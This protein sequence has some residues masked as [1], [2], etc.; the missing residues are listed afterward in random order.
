MNIKTHSGRAVKLSDATF[1]REYNEGL[2]HQA[3]TAYLAGARQGSKAQKNRA[4]VRGG[5]AK[6]WRQKGTGHAR[7]GSN[8]SP[9]WRGG[10][11]T[12]AARPRDHRQKI[13]RKQY[14]AAMQCIFSELARSQRL[15]L[16]DAFKADKPSTRA[17]DAKL[18]ELDLYSALVVTEE[19]DENLY[20]SIRNIPD[21]GVCGVAE[22]DPASLIRFDKVLMTVGAVKKVEAWLG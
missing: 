10:G 13:N 3:V 11:V 17:M 22:L 4:A 12:F 16:V 6:P 5:G 15:V 8:N 1:A 14:R 2:V 20:L 7:A 9:I 21:I 19:V 18:L